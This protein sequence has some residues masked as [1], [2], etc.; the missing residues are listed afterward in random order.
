MAVADQQKKGAEL[1]VLYVETLR[2][3]GKHKGML[4]QIFTK[5]QNKIQD[6]AKLFRLIDMIDSTSWLVMGAD[7]KGDIYEGILERNAE[8]T[9]SGA[10]QYFT[11]RSLIRAMVECIRPEPNKTI[12]DPSCGTG[13][14]F[15]AAYDFF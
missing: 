15:L 6:P 9:K 5:A 13:G 12:A 3:L 11:P 10:G 7:V 14:F 2:E 1:E 4:G 8:D